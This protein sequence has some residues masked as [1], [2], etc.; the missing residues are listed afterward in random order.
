MFLFIKDDTTESLGIAW[1]LFPCRMSVLNWLFDLISSMF[2]NGNILSLYSTVNF[3]S[4]CKLFNT[5]WNFFKLSSPF[6]QNMKK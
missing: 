5:E 1:N 6:G 4:G 3:K 2:R